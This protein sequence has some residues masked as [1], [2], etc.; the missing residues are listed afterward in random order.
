MGRYFRGMEYEHAICRAAEKLAGDF[1]AVADKLVRAM[2]GEAGHIPSI[3]LDFA[4]HARRIR[5]RQS[6]APVTRQEVRDI[7]ERGDACQ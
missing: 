2:E 4:R 5:D 7:I 6:S 3:A 1:Q